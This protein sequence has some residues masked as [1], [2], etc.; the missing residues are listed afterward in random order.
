MYRRMEQKKNKEVINPNKLYFQ[1]IGIE[2]VMRL[3]NILLLLS[4]LTSLKPLNLHNFGDQPL[5]SQ[6]ILHNVLYFW[7]QHNLTILE[8]QKYKFVKN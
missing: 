2:E 4:K 3:R 8:C 5:F 7:N 6:C 1:F